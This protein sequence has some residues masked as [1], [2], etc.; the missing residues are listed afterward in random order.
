MDNKTFTRHP[1]GDLVDGLPPAANNKWIV[2]VTRKL[3]PVSY[4][5]IRAQRWASLDPQKIGATYH[6]PIDILFGLE[7]CES[8]S[9]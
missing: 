3:F 7:T 2:F 8:I 5:I 4:K 9:L 1:G 6:I